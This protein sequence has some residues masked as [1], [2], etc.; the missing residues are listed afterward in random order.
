MFHSEYSGFV[1]LT[2][3]SCVANRHFVLLILFKI[4]MHLLLEVYLRQWC[5]LRINTSDDVYQCLFAETQL[6]LAYPSDT[7]VD[8]YGCQL[9][10]D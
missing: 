1:L 7:K 8:N 10:V 9:C 6:L 2:N 5:V 4:E 3:A